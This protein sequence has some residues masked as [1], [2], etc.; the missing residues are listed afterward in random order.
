MAYATAWT[1]ISEFTSEFGGL[2]QYQ[3][4]DAFYNKASPSTKRHDKT[5]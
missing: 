5:A 4:P 1:L 3:P 2:A